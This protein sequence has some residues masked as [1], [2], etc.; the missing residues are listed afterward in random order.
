MDRPIPTEA[1]WEYQ[2]PLGPTD[3]MIL[4]W[5]T[6]EHTMDFMEL[7]ERADLYVWFVEQYAYTL[8]TPATAGDERKDG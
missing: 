5:R 3:G 7:E 6:I 8:R 1:S 4:A 2:E